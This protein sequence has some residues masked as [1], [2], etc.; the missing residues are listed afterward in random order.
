[1]AEE[2]K[3]SILLVDDMK[4]MRD[5]IEN[6]IKENEK[7][8]KN[9]VDVILDITKAENGEEAVLLYARDKHDIVIMDLCMQTMDGLTASRE[10]LEINPLAKIIGMASE[11][12]DNVEEFKQCG[13]KYFV[14][15]PFQSTY[16]NSKINILINEIF[17]ENPIKELV[18]KKKK[19]SLIQKIFS[20]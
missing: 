20:K 15:K 1:M 17:Q 10:I 11:G 5:S 18:L 8:Y 12:D 6:Y 3:I 7:I 13:I 19:K 16:I 14:E 4:F 9:E 2:I